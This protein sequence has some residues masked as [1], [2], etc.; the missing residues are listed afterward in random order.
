LK[1]ITLRNALLIALLVMAIVATG[2]FATLWLTAKT[3]RDELQDQLALATIVGQ[4]YVDHGFV[5]AFDSSDQ[6]AAGLKVELYKLANGKTIP[7]QEATVSEDG[8]YQFIIEPGTYYVLPVNTMPGYPGWS[9][10]IHLYSSGNI[11]AEEG[12]LYFGPTF[13]AR[14]DRGLG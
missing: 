9:C 4:A 1:E 6:P 10:I 7:I 8:H 5:G 12:G 3:E 2:V 11:L 13:L 14:E